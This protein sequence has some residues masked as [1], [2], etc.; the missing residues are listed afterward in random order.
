[1]DFKTAV[2]KTLLNE[3]IDS[4]EL[5]SE[6]TLALMED[7][8]FDTF[9]DVT[10]DEMVESGLVDCLEEAISKQAYVSAMN[11]A[12][13]GSWDEPDD[14]RP[15][16][17]PDKLV[18]RAKKH[19]GEKFAKDLSGIGKKRTK[20]KGYDSLASHAM[21]LKYTRNRTD[22]SG[23]LTPTAQKS[24]KQIF[25]INKKAAAQSKPYEKKPNLP[26]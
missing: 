12:Q 1:M 25:Q 19:H 7:N 26:K 24:L 16:V 9:S 6:E 17:D 22:K 14:E 8:P 21:G 15:T 10:L 23:K 13:R 4:S 2:V 18:A 11:R 20:A 3:K 5:I